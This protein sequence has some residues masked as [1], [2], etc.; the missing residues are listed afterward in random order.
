M[1]TEATASEWILPNAVTI[2]HWGAYGRL[3]RL[4]VNGARRR[5]W[6]TLV[7]F[8]KHPGA[9]PR[10]SPFVTTAEES[11]MPFNQRVFQGSS[12]R[13]GRLARGRCSPQP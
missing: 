1:L 9:L 8:W 12:L 10:T 2:G 11:S 13:R 3:A 4:R 5:Q 6:L 7:A